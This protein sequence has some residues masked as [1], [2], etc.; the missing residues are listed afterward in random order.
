M[1]MALEGEAL[2]KMVSALKVTIVRESSLTGLMK[3][4]RSKKHRLLGSKL[5]LVL[6]GL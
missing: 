2:T 5:P 1:S 6:G 3:T 4:V